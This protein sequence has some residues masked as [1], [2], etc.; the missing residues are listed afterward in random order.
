MNVLRRIFLNSRK[1]RRKDEKQ[2]FFVRCK[3][4][5][6]YPFLRQ[7]ILQNNNLFQKRDNCLKNRQKT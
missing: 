6:N 4:T 2:F 1:E 7:N 5:N 3:R